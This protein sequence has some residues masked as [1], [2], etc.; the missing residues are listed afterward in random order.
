VAL[1]AALAAAG[2]A[3]QATAAAVRQSWPPFAL[4]AGLLLIGVSADADGL[5]AATGAWLSRLPGSSRTFF[6]I[7]LA[8]VALVTAVLNLDTAVVFVTPVLLAAAS[9]RGLTTRPFL[10]GSIAMCNAASLVLPGSNLT[11]L[12]VLAREPVPGATFAWHMLPASMAAI[13]VTGGLLMLLFHRELP[14]AQRRVQTAGAALNLG[15]GVIGAVLAVA[16]VVALRAPALP[17]LVTGALAVAVS[18]AMRRLDWRRLAAGVDLK[19]LAALFLA[20]VSL[21]ALA[22]SWRGPGQLVAAAGTWQTA[23]LGAGLSLL[24][25]NL[26][27]AVLLTARPPAHPRALLIGLNIGPNLAV[28]GA[29]SAILWLQVARAAGARPSIRFYSRVGLVVAPLALA[30]ALLAL[31]ASGV[32]GL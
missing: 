4:V 3:S 10:Y 25:N 31:S 7:S 24:V 1:A 18:L 6:A 17:V 28:T 29:L 19:L 13:V 22:R 32:S 2:A 30:V 27:A 5:F 26:P 9:A 15:P 16:F 23:A 12:L 20:A 21:G 14:V 8:L 11:N